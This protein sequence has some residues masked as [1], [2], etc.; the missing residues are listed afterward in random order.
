MQWVCGVV[1]VSKSRAKDQGELK[2]LR[3]GTERSPWLAVAAGP[4]VGWPGCN[5]DEHGHILWEKINQASLSCLYMLLAEGQVPWLEGVTVG[6]LK[7]GVHHHHNAHPSSPVLLE[8]QVNG[9]LAFLFTNWQSQLMYLC[10]ITAQ[11]LAMSMRLKQK[12]GWWVQGSAEAWWMRGWTMHWLQLCVSGLKITPAFQRNVFV[13]ESLKG[14]SKRPRSEQPLGESQ[15][16]ELL[17]RVLPRKAGWAPE[18][19]TC[20]C[21]Y[22]LCVQGNKTVYVM[23]DK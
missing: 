5:R 4:P 20:S 17:G 22:A 12:P 2:Y 9:T 15:E 6:I 1:Q 7:Q 8:A 16:T 21:L 14:C 11:H 18:Q 13:M 19:G 23:Y 10:V 3:R